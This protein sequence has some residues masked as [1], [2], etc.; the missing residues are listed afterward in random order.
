[1]KHSI[2]LFAFIALFIGAAYSQASFGIRAGVNH[3]TLQG[4]TVTSL[5]HLLEFGEDYIDTRNRTAFF[6]GGFVQIPVSEKISIEPG[7]YY[8]QKGY[9]VFGRLS[10][11][12]NEFLTASGSAR[13]ESH[14]IDIPLVVNIHL[15]D[16][17]YLYGGPQFS[18]L[19]STN[20]DLRA[21]ALGINVFRKNLD[22]TDAFHR[23]DWSLTGGA[24]YQFS[25]GITINAGYD[26]GLQRIDKNSMLKTYNRTIKLGL[27]FKF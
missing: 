12:K 21:G 3:S 4:E 9:A 10:V 27:G 1:M 22:I 6:A 20:L 19:A 17:L 2:L 5:D 15:T 13:L 14:Y 24:G 16:G 7:L 25:N 26:H 23:N 18:Y 11:D 8:S